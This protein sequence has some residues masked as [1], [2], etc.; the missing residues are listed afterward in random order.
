MRVT[1]WQHIYS[2]V[3]KEQSPTRRR[4]YQTLF[5]TH[6]GL[7]EAEVFA[8]E[9]R[10]QYYATENNP[11]KYQFYMLPGNNKAAISKIMP[12]AGLDEFGRKGRYLA[13][14]LIISKNEF[15][16]LDYCPMGLFVS[17]WFVSN[18]K[19]AFSQGDIK[20]GNISAKR[21]EVSDTW[22]EGAIQTARKWD[23]AQLTKLLQLGWQAAR[24]K[25]RRQSIILLGKDNQI[26]SLLAAMFLLTQPGKRPHLTFDTHVYGCDWT[27]DW[28][29]WAWGGLLVPEQVFTLV[30]WCEC[31]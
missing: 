4:G 21:I 22:M 13:H 14:S 5:Y 27:R 20:R 16:K 24:I 3:P 8:L 17:R 7:S 25:E 29:F 10:S 26:M 31:W 9:D 28:P 11:T 2:N 6:S 1:V 15:Q 19:E 12:L 18:L 23:L 30:W